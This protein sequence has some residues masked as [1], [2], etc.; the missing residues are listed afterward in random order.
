MENKFEEVNN[1]L[2]E[3]FAKLYK[4]DHIDYKK[5]LPDELY[6]FVRRGVE[7]TGLPVGIWV[8][9]YYAYEQYKHPLWIYVEN[10][11]GD[12][13]N[14][15]AFTI[16][17][18]PLVI[19]DSK[20]K[21][22]ISPDGIAKIKDYIVNNL[23]ILKSVGRKE[24]DY[25]RFLKEEKTVITSKNL[26]RKFLN[27]MGVLNTNISGVGFN[28]QVMECRKVSHGPRIKFQP[29]PS[30]QIP[31]SWPFI[32]MNGK[33]QGEY[34]KSYV[35]KYMSK[36]IEFKNL[37]EYIIYKLWFDEEYS[38]DDFKRDMRCF[39]NGV[40]T[41]PSNPTQRFFCGYEKI[42]LKSGYFQFKD[43]KGNLLTNEVFK[44][45]NN[46]KPQATGCFAVVTALN[47]KKYWL[48][49]NGKLIKWVDTYSTKIR[50]D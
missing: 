1:K 32:Q 47:D 38:F 19:T 35:N 23:E 21:I 36:L 27:E 44:K 15:I 22:K 26:P 40:I 28:I 20:T 9:E 2:D 34:N 43:E 39:K 4:T 8:D 45:A 6:N 11:K 33:I 46:F 12:Y 17:S 31:D 37:N 18:N 16:S 48:D 7:I 3:F 25:D 24:I 41:N 29:D 42:T 13:E 10:T 50:P 49:T 30:N 14:L 5:N